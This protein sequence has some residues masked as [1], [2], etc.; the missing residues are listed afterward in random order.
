MISSSLNNTLGSTQ[1]TDA[2]IRK[3]DHLKVSQGK[4]FC[5][6]YHMEAGQASQVAPYTL[7][8]EFACN[9]GDA[10]SSPVLGRSPGGGH[11]SPLQYSCLG[12]PRDREIWRATVHE[13]T[14]SHSSETAEHTRVYVGR[15]LV[16][17]VQTEHYCLLLI[18]H[19]QTLA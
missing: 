13:T 8:K 18:S 9:A 6:C 19:F 10:S 15:S 7:G 12:N 3:T 1:A 14:K 4:H 5:F 11:S 17:Y 2:F 16:E